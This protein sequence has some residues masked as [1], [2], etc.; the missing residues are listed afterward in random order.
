MYCIGIDIGTSSICGVAYDLHT[1]QCLTVARE[2]DT[3][4]FSDNQWEKRQKVGQ[5]EAIVR[6]MLQ[7]FQ[8]QCKDIL[9]I[10]LTGQMHG[11]LYTD[12][13]GEALSPLYTWQDG[14]GNLIYKNN[15]SYVDCLNQASGYPLATGYGLITHFYNQC[16]GEVPDGAH[17]L[18]TIMD[19]IAMKLCNREHPL[20]DPSNA[21]GLGLFDK[22]QLR[23]DIPACVAAGISPDILPEV[24]QP[25]TLVGHYGDIPVYTAIGDNQAAY[26]GA[27]QDFQCSIHVTVG[28][29][30]QLSVYSD[31]YMEVEGMDTRPL[32]TGGYLL[33]GAPLCGGAS[34]A[35]LKNF[36]VEV[37]KFFTGQQWNAKDVYRM[38]ANVPY[39]HS[40]E[41]D[42]RVETLFSGTRLQPEKRGR[43]NGISLS[44]LTPENL[45]RGFLMGISRELH[46]FYRLLPEEIRQNKT[47]LIGSGNGIR[48]NP[49]LKKIFEECFEMPLRLSEIQEE[50]AFGACMCVSKWTNLKKL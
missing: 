20:A 27:V 23:F 12:E 5:I 40:T 39:R 22:K 1:K 36:F 38:M 28:T 37:L 7:Q 30:S 17:K 47:L 45:V 15:R 8:K 14:R 31:Q 13:H 4:L 6:G 49:L 35:M 29:S 44:N 48:K 41:D 24:V 46:D 2:N 43:I 10:C 34:F 33:V 16:N 26:L 32:P 9:G 3:N 25:G 11:I 19:Y 42:L 50:A 21:A 18:C